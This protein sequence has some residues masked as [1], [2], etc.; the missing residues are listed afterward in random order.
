[1]KASIWLLLALMATGLEAR[2]ASAPAPGESPGA[3]I[4]PLEPRLPLVRPAPSRPQFYT[5]MP[6]DLVR[7][8]TLNPLSGSREDTSRLSR[9]D[10]EVI[11]PNARVREYVTPMP[12]VVHDPF[13]PM[14]RLPE[15]PPAIPRGPMRP[16]KR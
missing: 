16:K 10:I 1:M 15:L 14:P 11:A 13:P 3:P 9:V 4:P 12:I 7:I 6:M 5:D 2:P 8:R